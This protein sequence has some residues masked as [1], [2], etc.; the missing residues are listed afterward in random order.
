[1][2]RPANK[3]VVTPRRIPR[4]GAGEQIGHP[5]ESRQHW[6]EAAPDL[7]DV[8]LDKVLEIRQALEENW[9][10]DEEI[11]NETIQRL[12]DDPYFTG[13]CSK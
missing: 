9:Y 1:M 13:D 11:L 4:T 3:P 6:E 5:S 7:S 2:N 10:D 8:R 12:S